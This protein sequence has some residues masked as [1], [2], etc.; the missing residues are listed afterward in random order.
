MFSSVIK[1]LSQSYHRM[2]QQIFRE[3]IFVGI[4]FIVCLVG[5]LFGYFE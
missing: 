3:H 5:N 4:I 2:P 1:N